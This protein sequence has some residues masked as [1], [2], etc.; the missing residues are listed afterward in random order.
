MD[1]LIHA[2]NVLFLLSYSVRD[3]LLLRVLTVVAIVSLLPYYAANELYPPIWWN[4]VFIAINLYQVYRLLLE[5]RPVTLSLEEQRLYR[6]G[7]H[8]LSPR[9]F[10]RLLQQ[11][12]WESCE[13]EAV[14]VE[15]GATLDRLT[16]LAAGAARVEVGGRTVSGLGPGHFVGEMSYIS[17]EPACAR[18]VAD[19]GSRYVHWARTNLERLLGDRPDLRAT[20]QGIIGTDLASK[21][22]RGIGPE[23]ARSESP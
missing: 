6:L 2:A 16:V 10:L 14:L 13:G 12:R 23:P 18:V 4:S 9:D 20:L 7:F 21:L 3:I 19:A 15:Q 17:G 8:R 22:R 5:R 1:V 11:A